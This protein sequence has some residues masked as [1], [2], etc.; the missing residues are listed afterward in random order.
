MRRRRPECAAF[1]NR[2]LSWDFDRVILA[3]G[4]MIDSGAK[5]AA[6]CAWRFA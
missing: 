3:H 5:P 6:E 1:L 2:L 4:A